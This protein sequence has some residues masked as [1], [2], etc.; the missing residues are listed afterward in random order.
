[1]KRYKRKLIAPNKTLHHH[2]GVQQ[3]NKKLIQFP[4]P[5]HNEI[6]PWARRANG[7]RQF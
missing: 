7:Y 2:Y 5:L 3:R 1:M 6:V 4:M